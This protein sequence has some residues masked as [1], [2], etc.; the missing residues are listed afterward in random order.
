MFLLA[1]IPA[2]AQVQVLA[3]CVELAAREGFPT[4]TLTKAQAAKARIRMAQLSERDP[5]VKQCRTAIRV[6]QSMMKD[7]EK[8]TTSVVQSLP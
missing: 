2:G 8:A 1:A 7:M 6:A 3:D 4:D 5:L